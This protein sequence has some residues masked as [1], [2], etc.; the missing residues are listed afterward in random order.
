MK[1][2]IILFITGVLLLFTGF[3]K[4]RHFLLAL[5]LLGT[6][7]ALAVVLTDLWTGNYGGLNDQF[8]PMLHFDRYALAFSAVALTN[9]FL[10]FGL[11]RWGFRQLSETLGDNY[12]L[13][14]FSLCGAL[15]MFAF[16]NIVMLFLGIE[17]LSIPLYVLAG[18][19]RDSLA[20]NEAALKYFLMGSFAT[21]I[22][23]FGIAMMYGA[24]AS[25]DLQTIATDLQDGRH[26]VPMLHT[27]ILM[28]LIGLGFKISAAPFHF[29]AP[30]VYQG[31]PNMVTTYMASVV[32]TAGI[33]AFF[34]LFAVA[35]PT[36]MAFWSVPVA[37][38]AGL[39]MLLA[40][41]TALFQS[42][43]KR[44]M[45]YSSIAHAGYLLLG[46]L[47][48]GQDGT[49][50]ALLLYLLSY[51]VATISA[52][53]V[54]MIVAEE[55]LD[56]SI[57]AFNGLSRK[58]PLLAAAMVV[59]ML[60]LAGIPPTAGFFGKYF[61]FSTAFEKYTWLVALAVV[62]SAVSIYYYFKVI[63]A[64]YFSREH[65]DYTVRTPLGFRLVV[66]AGMILIAA[67]ALAPG[68]VY[69]IM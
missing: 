59:A 32:K 36:A 51:G 19:R 13:I 64:M 52:F 40:N 18:S 49:V 23:L 30:D 65:N 31:S 26:S 56:G 50:G 29:W 55:N 7:L 3:L 33:G 1:A 35:F 67:L 5:S 25:F 58:Q 38:I 45:A 68:V 42:D 62:N 48:A 11:S 10:L 41:F 63:I 15:C 46:I 54:Y 4:K 47:S 27:G 69:G 60:S 53:A 17:I 8:K 66:I 2:L 28:I 16:N 14:L 20:S 39:T 43:F 44:L 34:K 22:L 61:L 9:A 12:G 37:V 57:G 6:G 24:T 21:G